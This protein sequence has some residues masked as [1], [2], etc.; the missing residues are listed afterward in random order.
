MISK[1]LKKCIVFLAG[2]SVLCLFINVNLINAETVEPP[3]QNDKERVCEIVFLNNEAVD[4]DTLMR[5]VEE[6]SPD[7]RQ[8]CIEKM[9]C[10]QINTIADVVMDY[11]L[12]KGYLMVIV[13]LPKCGLQDPCLKYD[14]KL[15]ISIS[16]GEVG[17]I[18]VVDKISLPLQELSAPEPEVTGNLI[19]S[20]KRVYYD[21]RVLTRYFNPQMR[22]KVIN[23][24][25]LERGSL[26]AKEVLGIKT[27]LII[28]Q[29][30]S[31]EEQDPFQSVNCEELFD[32][33]QVIDLF[34][35]QG[36]RKFDILL[37][38]EMEK[39][40]PYEFSLDYNN[41][42]S[43][44]VSRSRYGMFFKTADPWWGS[45]FSFR[46]S[47]GDYL[48]DTSLLILD[49]AIPL[50]G[51]GTELVLNYLYG[52]YVVGGSDFADLGLEGETNI[53]GSSLVHPLIKK[54]NMNLDLKLDY[55]HKKVEHYLYNTSLENIDELD[56]FGVELN[57]DILESWFR[58]GK[59]YLTLGC[60][61]GEIDVDDIYDPTRFDAGDE[62]FRLLLNAT[63][64]QY[65]TQN[66]NF[67]FR[68]AGQYSSDRLLPNEQWFLG[69]YGTVRGHEP[70]AYIGDSGYVV[71]GELAF[72]PPFVGDFDL[73]VFN[74]RK[75][76]ADL[77]QFSLFYDYGGVYTNDHYEVLGEKE[78]VSLGG[79]GI[80][81]RL[82][83]E[84]IFNLKFDAGFP[85]HQKEQDDDFYP[86]VMVVFNF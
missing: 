67:M 15:I 66:M 30:K 14:G 3:P 59:N 24:E 75:R 52:D 36:K 33:Q 64:V 5:Q 58:A 86:Y 25:L 7:W 73:T 82:Y 12:N 11:Y 6:T 31:A 49:Y 35:E 71:S 34:T 47:T 20:A 65:I 4:N 69:G 17:D 28:M 50:N 39:T 23:E 45:K 16:E 85:T 79:Y 51:Y 48:G 70:S 41:F 68:A 78:S 80:G 60:V 9:T 26:L 8:F 72:A 38:T 61:Y 32:C 46:G 57:F 76:V 62:Y 42:G 83:Y 55:K 54:K 77:L 29:Q 63:R 10:E 84:D 22:H 43:K 27:D 1:K 18:K 74:T 19:P 53:Y 2:M 44:N 21:D 37:A 81:L 56:S 40:F 13:N